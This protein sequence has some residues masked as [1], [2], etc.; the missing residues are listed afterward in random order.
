MVANAEMAETNIAEAHG[1]RCKECSGLGSTL[2]LNG[3]VTTK[4]ASRCNRCGGTGVEPVDPMVHIAELTKR[5]ASLEAQVAK[6]LS[7]N[8]TTRRS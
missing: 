3:A 4:S 7:R 8:R 1:P 5:L 6:L 2:R